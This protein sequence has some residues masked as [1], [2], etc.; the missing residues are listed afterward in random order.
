MKSKNNKSSE[1]LNSIYN[2][3]FKKKPI[4]FIQY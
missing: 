3:I 2:F 4:I 1:D